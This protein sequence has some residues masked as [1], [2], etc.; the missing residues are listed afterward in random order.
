MSLQNLSSNPCIAICD[1]IEKD[2]AEYSRWLANRYVAVSIKEIDDNKAQY[3]MD[4]PCS[5]PCHQCGGP[6]K[7][8]DYVC[9]GHCYS[10]FKQSEE[11][12]LLYGNK[13]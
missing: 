5:D 4:R 13:L 8:G 9:W 10:C 3:D 1:Q 12:Y 2:N 6:M 11:E 7:V